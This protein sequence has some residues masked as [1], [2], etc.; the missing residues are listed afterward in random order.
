MLLKDIQSMQ[1]REIHHLNWRAKM[2]SSSEEL[3][4]D[5][6]LANLGKI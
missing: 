6:E 3:L 5:E 1:F 4:S 2:L